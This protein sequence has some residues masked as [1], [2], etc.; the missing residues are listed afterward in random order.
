MPLKNKITPRIDI[1]TG[2]SCNMQCRFCYYVKS[3]TRCLDEDLTT[4]QVKSMLRYAR[5][6]GKYI[7]DFTGGEPTIRPDIFELCLSILN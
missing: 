2:H 6:K 3:N 7:V 5:K 1:N 4:R